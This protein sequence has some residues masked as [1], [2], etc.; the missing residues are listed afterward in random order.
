MV[1]IS[2][3]TAAPGHTI[4][5]NGVVFP[6]AAVP[7]L[8]GE[9]LNAAGLAAQIN[10]LLPALNAGAVGAVVTVQ[11]AD[12]GEQTITLAAIAGFL[13]TE[14]LILQAQTLME[15]DVSELVP[16]ATTVVA[17]VDNLAGNTD[18]AEVAVSLTRAHSYY[19]PVVQAIA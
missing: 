8:P 9:W 3:A 19:A 7:A 4:T 12:P 16:G 13:V 1:T 17:V 14:V 10:A 11:A 2:D 15:V 6:F 18:N 5:I